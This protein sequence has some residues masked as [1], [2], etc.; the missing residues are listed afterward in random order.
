MAKVYGSAEGVESIASGLI[1]NFHAELGTARI[2]YCFVDSVGTKGGREL[3]G[4]VRKFAGFQEWALEMDFAV[5]VG[6]DKW[7]DLTESQRTALIDHLLERCTGEE[8]EDS[9]EMRWKIREPDV[10]EFSSI[11][12]RQGAWNEDL[13]GFVSV[14]QG[15][16]ID[17]IIEEEGE[18]NVDELVDTNSAES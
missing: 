10:Q 5:E 16:K 8:D 11:L 9:G 2:L 17:D 15:I 13:Q 12:H 1:A 3:A 7:N 4:K 18:V 6:L 14:A